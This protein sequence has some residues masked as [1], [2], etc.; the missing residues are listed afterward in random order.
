MKNTVRLTKSGLI[1][2]TAI[3][4]ASYTSRISLFVPTND[5]L[6]YTMYVLY[7]YMIVDLFDIPYKKGR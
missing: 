1:V 2:A 3:L 6:K 5:A 7:T 4:I